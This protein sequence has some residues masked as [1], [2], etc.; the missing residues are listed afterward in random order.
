MKISDVFVIMRNYPVVKLIS[1]L[2][3]V[4]H[5]IGVDATQLTHQ[6]VEFSN[7]KTVKKTIGGVGV[8]GCDFNFASAANANEQVI[9]LGAIIPAFARVLDVKTRTKAAFN[10]KSIAI[11][12]WAVTSN[13][14]TIVTASVHGLVTG[15]SVVIAGMTE[16]ACNGTHSVT[17]T[18]TTTFTFALTHANAATTAD[19]TGTATPT[20]TLV[21]ET[22][23]SS[24]GHE[25]IG[26]TTIKAL[27]AITYMPTDHVMTVAPA[28]AASKVYVSATPNVFWANMTSGIVEVIVSYIEV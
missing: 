11:A 27:D 22:G 12:S 23:N 25:F 26:S 9:D 8:A 5:T 7:L 14:C 17:V 21:A 16:T 10:S 24:S 15:N 19:T 28:A 13:V 1:R 6:G 2:L 20:V 18:N 3:N 4:E